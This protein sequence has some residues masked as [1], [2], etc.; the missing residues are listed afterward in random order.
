MDTVQQFHD[1]K[2]D[3]FSPKGLPGMLNVLTILTFIGCT[4]FF[5]SSFY[6][7]FTTCKQVETLQQLAN[8]DDNPVA[9]FIATAAESAQRQCEQ[10]VPLLAIN[11]IGIGLCLAGAL[12]MRKLKKSGFYIYSIGEIIAP[13]ASAIIIGGSFGIMTALGFL[14]PA[15]FVILYATQLKHLNQ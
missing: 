6:S 8:S 15:L 2:V 3:D 11:L 1:D 13:I 5:F 14:F 7:F 10:R 12:Q 4:V 9:G